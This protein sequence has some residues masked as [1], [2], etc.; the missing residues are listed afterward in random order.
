MLLARRS[1]RELRPGQ[2]AL[3]IVIMSIVLWQRM[4]NLGWTVVSDIAPKK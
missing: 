3:V 1:S 2:N 4:T